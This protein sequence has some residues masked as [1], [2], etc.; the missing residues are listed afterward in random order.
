MSEKTKIKP[1]KPKYTKPPRDVRKSLNRAIIVPNFE[2]T[3]EGIKKFQEEME[4]LRNQEQSSKK[5]K[6]KKPKPQKSKTPE[7]I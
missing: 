4:Q 2:L 1:K 5:L 3:P 7:P 6:L